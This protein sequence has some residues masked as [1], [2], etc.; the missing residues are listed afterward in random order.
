MLEALLTDRLVFT[1]TT[2]TGGAA[3]Y[4]GCRGGSRSGAFSAESSVHKVWRPRQV[5]NLRPPV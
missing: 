1:P 4:T 5:S 2:D 3:C